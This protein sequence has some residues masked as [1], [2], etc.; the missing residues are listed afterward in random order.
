MSVKEQL[1]R[2]IERLP[3]NILEEVFDFVT[4]I[5]RRRLSEA[6]GRVWTDF[7]LS[8]GSFDFWNDPEEVEYSLADLKGSS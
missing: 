1:F 4:F 7:A 5:R 3:E 6:E 2:E 8:T